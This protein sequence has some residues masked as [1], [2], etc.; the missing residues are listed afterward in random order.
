[1]ASVKS[2]I[3]W[4]GHW[5]RFSSVSPSITGKGK[6]GEFF[7]P[8]KSTCS[9]TTSL[10]AQRQPQPP[11]TRWGNLPRQR[12]AC[13][14]LNKH[15][16]CE[17]ILHCNSSVCL[18]SWTIIVVGWINLS[19]LIGKQSVQAESM[20]S[21]VLFEQSGPMVQLQHQQFGLHDSQTSYNGKKK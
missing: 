9:F 8:W 4:R 15:T 1:M 20:H 10:F 14:T 21:W 5:L 2:V 7:L 17:N 18:D 6:H 3:I 13:L 16:C 11:Q 12:T 19:S